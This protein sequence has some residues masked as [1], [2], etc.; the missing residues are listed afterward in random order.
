MVRCLRFFS[1][2]IGLFTGGCAFDIAHVSSE[3]TLFSPQPEP[4]KSFVMK[5][6][7]EITQAPCGYDRTL[8][9][10]THWDLVGTI[11]EGEVYKPQNQVLTVECSHVFEAYLVLV[12][13]FMIGF[14][15][16]VEGEFVPISDKVA[17]PITS[18]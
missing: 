6:T 2:L 14:Y 17:L 5:D 9:A 16:P 10:G 12:N 1:L 11:P 8:R 7:V 18:H 4:R 15:L 3:P 13:G